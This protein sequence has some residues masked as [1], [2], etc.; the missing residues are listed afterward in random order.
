MRL[1]NKATPT[2]IAEV[3]PLDQSA[4]QAETVVCHCFFAAA[5]TLNYALFSP[6]QVGH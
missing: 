1:T 4:N 5:F 2:A 6:E 3:I